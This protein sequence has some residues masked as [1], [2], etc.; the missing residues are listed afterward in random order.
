MSNSPIEWQKSSYSTNGNNCIESSHSLLSAGVVPVRDSKNPKGP[1]LTIGAE[2]W[3]SFVAAAG[4][5]EL[6]A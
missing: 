4:S 2:A 5:G 3:S 6:T 1:M